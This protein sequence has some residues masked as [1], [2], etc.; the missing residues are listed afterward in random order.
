MTCKENSKENS[1]T[2]T[3]AAPTRAC[4]NVKFTGEEDEQLNSGIK[5]YGKTAWASILR[6]T[7]FKFHESRTRDSLR[8]RAGSAAFKK[9]FKIA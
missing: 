9:R 6:D 7:N 2:N 5:K 4:K 3:T 8:V 1:E